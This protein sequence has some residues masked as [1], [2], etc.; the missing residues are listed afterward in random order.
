MAKKP[1]IILSRELIFKS[2]MQLDLLKERCGRMPKSP[3]SSADTCSNSPNKQCQCVTSKLQTD[4]CRRL[5]EEQYLFN[6]INNKIY[7]ML[8]DPSTLNKLKLESNAGI[9]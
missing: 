3:E 7:S 2:M 6:F 5:S 4:L 8:A 1:E 9:I